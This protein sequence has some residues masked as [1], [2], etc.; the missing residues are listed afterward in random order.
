MR[1]LLVIAC[2]VLLAGF[3][4]AAFATTQEEAP[5][6]IP[7]ETV[8]PDSSE[9]FGSCG[10]NICGKKEYCCNASCG[11]CVPFGWSCT[12]ESCNLTD[13]EEVVPEE[14]EQPEETSLFP[15][16]VPFPLPDPGT[17]GGNVCGK[18]E[19]CCNASCGTCAPIGASCTQQ[20]CNP[21]E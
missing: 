7:A 1:K 3:G 8:I 10:G 13:E 18:G 17:C 6:P 12:Q 5:A 9:E 4:T 20:V 16:P 14:V 2:L 21:T 15:T 19:Y 11:I